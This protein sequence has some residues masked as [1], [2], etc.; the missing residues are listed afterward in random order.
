MVR[1]LEVTGKEVCDHA[2]I[3]EEINIFFEETFKCHQGKSFTNLSNILKSIHLPC[4]TNEQKDFCE[5]E[6]GEREL[7][8][9]LKP[10]LNNKPQGMMD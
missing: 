3:N 8:N 5:I 4:L 6:L 1:K 10:M 7:C 2:K 9:A